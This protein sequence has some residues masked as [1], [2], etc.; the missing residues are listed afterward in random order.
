MI[1]VKTYRPFRRFVLIRFKFSLLCLFLLTVILFGTVIWMSE[2]C[3]SSESMHFVMQMQ[4]T[5]WQLHTADELQQ[6]KEAKSCFQPEN[7]RVF[8]NVQLLKDV[9]EAEE[10][11]KPGK[12][13]FFHETS[14]IQNGIAVLNSRWWVECQEWR[15]K[16]YCLQN[17]TS[18]FW[19]LLMFSLSG[20]RVRL[21][22]QLSGIPNAMFLWFS[23]Q[24]LDFRKIWNRPS[25]EPCT[26]IQI[27]IFAISI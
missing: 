22:Q 15:F 25:C 2:N 5:S 20:K 24:K 23:L 13:I 26:L 17:F 6:I 18:N 9:L 8:E 14:C 12:A 19:I 4:S 21:N 1:Q 7:S 27:F 16:I 11:P 10:K 3:N